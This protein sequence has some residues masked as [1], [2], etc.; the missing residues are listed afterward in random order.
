MQITEAIHNL[1]RAMEACG[2]NE[3]EWLIGLVPHIAEEVYRHVCRENKTEWQ[4]GVMCLE[5]V[6]L[7]PTVT[8]VLLNVNDENGNQAPA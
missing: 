5:G 6:M 4:G 8:G 2:I 1:R 3:D 7:L